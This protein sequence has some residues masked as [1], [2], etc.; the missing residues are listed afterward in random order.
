VTSA[1]AFRF[2]DDE[3]YYGDYPTDYRLYYFGVARR[4]EDG[5][6]KASYLTQYPELHGGDQEIELLGWTDERHIITLHHGSESS[7]LTFVVYDI[8]ATKRTTLTSFYEF[9]RDGVWIPAKRGRG[10]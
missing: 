1:F 6:W 2:S 5:S 10:L 8:Q 4:T 9:F 7:S 3:T